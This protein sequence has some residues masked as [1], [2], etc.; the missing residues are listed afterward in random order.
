M[1]EHYFSYCPECQSIY[2]FGYVDPEKQT[3]AEC[4]ECKKYYPSVEWIKEK[5]DCL[6]CPECGSTNVRIPV[7]EI[8]Y[9]YADMAKQWAKIEHIFTHDHDFGQAVCDSCG[10]VRDDIE[11]DPDEIWQWA[12]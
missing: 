12:C 10:E 2:Q 4:I 3:K 5:C 6:K 1:T 9:L 8:Y 7:E 11:I